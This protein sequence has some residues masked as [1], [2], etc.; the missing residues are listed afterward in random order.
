MQVRAAGVWR[1]LFGSRV[2][3]FFAESEHYSLYDR[4]SL[5]LFDGGTTQVR[6]L[7]QLGIRFFLMP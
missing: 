6:S 1:L 7:V 5:E 2:V 3:D 4:H